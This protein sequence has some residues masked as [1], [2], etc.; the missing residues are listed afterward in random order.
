M[1]V[2]MGVD[3]MGVCERVVLSGADVGVMSR[4]MKSAK[5]EEGRP[6]V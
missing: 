6:P 1:Y 3:V 4:L 2:M 5:E